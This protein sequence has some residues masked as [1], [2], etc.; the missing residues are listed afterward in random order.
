MAKIDSKITR[1]IREKKEMQNNLNNWLVVEKQIERSNIK[2]INWR[3]I[4]GHSLT[5]EITENKLKGLDSNNCFKYIKSK[6][7]I[8]NIDDLDI[9]ERLKISVSAR[10]AEQNARDNR[11]KRLK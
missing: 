8:K 7:L 10:Y 11:L 9:I 3:E 5:E 4:L 6:L 2:R 1:K